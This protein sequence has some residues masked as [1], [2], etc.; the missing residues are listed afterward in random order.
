[1]LSW[2]TGGNGTSRLPTFDVKVNPLTSIRVFLFVTE[3]VGRY[4]WAP[5]PFYSYI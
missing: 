3:G 1:M 4:L 5:R 2:R